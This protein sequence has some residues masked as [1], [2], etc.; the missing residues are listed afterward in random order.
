MRQGAMEICSVYTEWCLLVVG[1]FCV[2]HRHQCSVLLPSHDCWFG[3]NAASIYSSL[4]MTCLE[5]DEVIHEGQ[6]TPCFPEGK[7]NR[8][9]ARVHL[10]LLVIQIRDHPLQYFT[11]FESYYLE[12]V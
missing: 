11:F 10:E 4:D 1:M 8:L 2:E 5:Y 6:S 7:K 3:C 12:H 9:V